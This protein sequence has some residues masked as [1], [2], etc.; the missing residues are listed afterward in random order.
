MSAGSATAT[1]RA[2]SSSASAA[3]RAGRAVPHARPAAP[4]LHERADRGARG[5]AG[6][7]HQRACA[8]RGRA[9]RAARSSRP[10][11]SVLSARD[12]A[13]ALERQ[14]VGG[15]D[16]LRGGARRV[17]ERQ[18]RL[19]VRDR[20]VDAAEARGGQRPHGLGEQLRRQRQREVLPVVE[21]RGRAAPAF[22][23]AGERE[24]ATGHP[25]TPRQVIKDRRG[26][27]G[28]AP[29]RA[30]TGRRSSRTRARRTC[31]ACARRTGTSSSRGWPRP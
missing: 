29:R 25:H 20:H 31:R 27:P 12:R 26:R 23:I 8:R 18:R 9:R 24:W 28:S 10:G 22:C 2:P 3:A 4:G 15:A 21:A 7:E 13:V 19:L 14:R 5:A 16:R 1:A 11:A 17:G 6:A 30:R